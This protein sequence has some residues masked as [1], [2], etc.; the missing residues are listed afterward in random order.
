MI[1]HNRLAVIVLLGTTQTL[2]WASSF[3]LPAILG[4]RIAEDLGVSSTWFFAAFSAALVVSALVGPVHTRNSEALRCL[5]ICTPR[6]YRCGHDHN[7]CRPRFA[8][9]VSCS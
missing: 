3:Y 7:C 4:D 9:I 1:A 8:A 5:E 6:P 2:G